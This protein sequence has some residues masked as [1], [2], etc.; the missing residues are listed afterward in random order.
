MTAL[1][2][3]MRPLFPLLYSQPD[4]VYLDNASTVQKPQSVIDAMSAYLMTNYANIHRWQY[5]LAYHSE[6]LYIQ[7][8]KDV[9]TLLWWDY[10]EI[11]YTYNAT[12]ACNLIAQSLIVSGHICPWDTV[13]VGTWDHHASIV[14]WQL[15]ARQFWFEL[16]FI[17]LEKESLDIDWKQ[18]SDLLQNCSVK[19][20]LCSHVSNVTWCIYDMKRLRSLVSDDVFFGIDWSQA[21]PHL[22]IDVQDLTCDAY[23]LTGH[24]MMWPT[25][26]GVL[27]LKKL[28]LRKLSPILGWGGIIESVSTTWCTL[29]RT[30]EKFEPG[31]PNL[32]GAVGL[33]AACQ[34]YETH[35]LYQELHTHEFE[36]MQYAL[37]ILRSYHIDVLAD[38]SILIKSGIISFVIDNPIECTEYLTR[39]NICVRTGWH[40]AHPLLHRLWYEQ[41]VVRLSIYC[42]TT[43]EDIDRFGLF[44]GEYI[45]TMHI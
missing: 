39:H 18:L 36:L 25:G 2:H 10:R 37:S 22:H 11:I 1:W 34:F 29:V 19:A 21:V 42:Y 4:I 15:L 7:S 30:A 6:E 33:W 43:Q 24:K 12:Y 31:T 14:T 45:A 8:K 28:R 23:V 40:C 26:I 16:Q 32:V 13:M 27:W 9:A 44:L 38:Q 5:E 20:I 17:P 35:H 3:S 41:W